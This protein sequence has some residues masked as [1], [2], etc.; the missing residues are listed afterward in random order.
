[1]TLAL[2]ILFPRHDKYRVFCRFP[3]GVY[4]KIFLKKAVENYTA[5]VKHRL[6][7]KT[8]LFYFVFSFQR[9]IRYL[10]YVYTALFVIFHTV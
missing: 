1:M 3:G 4:P 8:F 6:H 10:F 2:Y 7:Q 5:E 9:R